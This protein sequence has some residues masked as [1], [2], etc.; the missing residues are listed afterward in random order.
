MKIIFIY[1][2]ITFLIAWALP[3]FVLVDCHF[4]CTWYI[5]CLTAH[6]VC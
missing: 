4:L 1:D 6:V 2:P 3:I 5:Y